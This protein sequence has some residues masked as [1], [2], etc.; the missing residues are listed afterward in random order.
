M[1]LEYYY[2][3]S[4][5]VAVLC[6]RKLT[7]SLATSLRMKPIFPWIFVSWMPYTIYP[8]AVPWR[9]LPNDALCSSWHAIQSTA[10]VPP[11]SPQVW[12]DS[13]TAS[14]SPPRTPQQDRGL[15]SCGLGDTCARTGWTTTRRCRAEQPTREIMYRCKGTATLSSILCKDFPA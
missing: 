8:G 1:T 2:C 10:T 3:S 5:Q 13:P 7:L 11:P 14:S 9:S 12:P 6:I 15:Q 4:S